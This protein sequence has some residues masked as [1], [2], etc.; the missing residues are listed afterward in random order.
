MSDRTRIALA[1][2]AA[3]GLVLAAIGAALLLVGADLSDAERA[4]LTPVLRERAA[5]VVVVSLL[6]LVPLVFILK[7]LFKR[8]VAAPRQLA[9]DAR[10]MLSA[11]PAHRATPV[12]T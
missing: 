9:E 1:L 5:S 8:Y 12:G 7:A 4:L 2:L 10:I 3:W 6:L 11:N